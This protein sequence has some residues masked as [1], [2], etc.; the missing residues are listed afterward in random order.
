M[1]FCNWSRV[2]DFLFFFGYPITVD[3]WYSCNRQ[4]RKA[5]CL[6]YLPFPLSCF[7]VNIWYKFS[8]MNF[9][10]A[11]VWSIRRSGCRIRRY[12]SKD[13]W[14]YFSNN[15]WVRKDFCSIIWFRFLKMLTFNLYNNMHL[16][17]YNTLF[18]WKLTKMSTIMAQMILT[19]NRIQI[20]LAKLSSKNGLM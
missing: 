5:S 11:G 3:L 16:V 15:M 10:N 12:Q 4:G 9:S 2:S 8:F 13:G 6:Q 19:N 14:S 1:L 17:F 20:Y 18:Q 7:A